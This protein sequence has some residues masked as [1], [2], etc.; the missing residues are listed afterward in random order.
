MSGR[1]NTKFQTFRKEPPQEKQ[2]SRQLRMCSCPSDTEAVIGDRTEENRKEQKWARSGFCDPNPLYSNPQLGSIPNTNSAAVPRW[3]RASHPGGMVIH[4]GL[5]TS[6]RPFLHR[7]TTRCS[8]PKGQRTTRMVRT[9]NRRVSKSAC[10]HQEA[11]H[12][13]ASWAQSPGRPTKPRMSA[14]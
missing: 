14:V 8:T 6:C 11:C 9:E 4:K 12:K 10:G 3:G 7:T 5:G 1:P 13:V 2:C